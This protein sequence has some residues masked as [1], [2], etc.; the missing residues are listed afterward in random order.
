MTMK[1]P[2]WRIPAISLT[3]MSIGCGAAG[4]PPPGDPFVGDWKLNP[5]RSKVTDVMNVQSVDGNKY[6]FDFGGG[7]ETIVADGTDQPGNSETTLSVT[8]EGPDAWKVVR[9]KAGSLLI[10][11]RWK[12]SQDRNTLSDDYTELAQDGQVSVHADY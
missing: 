1:F 3:A 7:S 9:K 2:A 6:A 5:S 8:I 10:S 11:A 4:R 12:L